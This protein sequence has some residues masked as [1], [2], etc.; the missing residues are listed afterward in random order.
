MSSFSSRIPSKAF[1]AFSNHISLGSP[2]LWVS[3]S[4]LFKTFTVLRSTSQIFCRMSLN[5]AA[6]IWMFVSPQTSHVE[7]LT[8]IVV[9]LG[10]EVFG[11]WLGREGRA[12]MV[13]ISALVKEIP[14]SSLAPSTMW[15]YDN[16]PAAQKRA[17]IQPCWQ[18]GIGLQGASMGLGKNTTELKWSV[19]LIAS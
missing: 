11:R 8:P 6:M 14:E 12:L 5:L 13:R 9:I 15:G 17:L 16:K 4:F 7:I 18:T 10:S 19:L 1:S 2:G 3:P